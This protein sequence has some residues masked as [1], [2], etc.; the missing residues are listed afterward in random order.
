MSKV[1]NIFRVAGNYIAEQHIDIHDNQNVYV[2]S[3]KPETTNQE[4]S[5][6]P[7]ASNDANVFCRIT[8]EARDAGKAKQVEEELRRAC[9]S[10]PKLIKAIRTN[11]AL[12]Y[13]DTQNLSSKELYD[14]LNEH[15]NLPFT[16]HNF[17]V[18][19]SKPIDI[20]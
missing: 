16:S 15:F 13:L 18:Y 2:G 17:T 12:G 10:A 1:T 5:D 9:V 14:L 19:R 6:E 7:A 20:H 4:A 11:E 3:E 8:K